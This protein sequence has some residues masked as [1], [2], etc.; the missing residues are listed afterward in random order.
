MIRFEPRTR[1]SARAAARRAARRGRGRA[2]SRRDPARASPARRSVRAFGLMAEGAAG[3]LFAFTETLTRATPLIFTGLAAAVAFRAQALQ[4]RRRRPAL[5]RR[6]RRRR[7]RRGR[8]RGAAL[9]ARSAD[10]GRRRARGR[11]ADARARRCCKLAARRRRGRDHA[12]AELRRAAVRADDARR[13]AQGPDGRRLAAIR[14]DPARRHAAAAVE[15][16]RA[17]CGLHRSARSPP[18]LVYVLIARTVLGLEIRAV[19]ENAGGRALSP[20]SR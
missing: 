10:P 2:R 16:M 7:D 17:A 14:A 5:C 19:G 11:P 12:A 15:R 4:Y 20:A 8:D 3:S 6:A 18:S 13:P 9:S 1:G